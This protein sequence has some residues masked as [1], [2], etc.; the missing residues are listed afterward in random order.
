LTPY[1]E[2]L[3]I[4]S[5]SSNLRHTLFGVLCAA[6]IVFGS[7]QAFAT[8]QARVGIGVACNPYSND[9]VDPRDLNYCAQAC[10]EAG[11]SYGSCTLSGYCDC[12]RV[13][14]GAG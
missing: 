1:P 3:M 13:R 5:L 10:V 9:P 14:P 7:V 12:R 6:S 8:A 2:D 11:Y 4:R